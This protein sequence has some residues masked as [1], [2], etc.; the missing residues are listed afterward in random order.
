MKHIH[1]ETE[2]LILRRFRE[3]DLE[4]LF[5]YLSDEEVVR[6]EPYR[7]MNLDEVRENLNWRIGA[8][9]MIA[10]EGKATGKLLGNLYLAREEFETMELG[11][12]FNRAF[13]GKGYAKESCTALINLC[14]QR[15]VHRIIA[16]CDPLNPASWH[17]LE[18]LGFRREAHL[19]ENVYFWKDNNGNPIWKDTYI[20]S[21][22][23]K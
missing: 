23:N 10:V 19:R 5:E 3:N 17:L 9:E 6:F 18:S 8:E 16:R 22:L 11:Y 4:D 1:A 21:K 20:Y 12:V 14:F 7:P 2:R 13:W 15:G